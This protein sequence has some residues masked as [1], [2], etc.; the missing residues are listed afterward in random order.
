[1]AKNHNNKAR[2][3]F[4]GNVK[5]YRKITDMT[6]EVLSN[7]TGLTKQYISNVENCNNNISLDNMN[8]IAGAFGVSL[9]LLLL[10]KSDI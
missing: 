7:K 6:Q 8:K 3:I 9:Y 4:A 5:K 1:M 2:Q 10:D